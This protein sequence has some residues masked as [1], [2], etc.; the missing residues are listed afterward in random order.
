MRPETLI[1]SLLILMSYPASL[2]S[3]EGDPQVSNEPQVVAGVAVVGRP[4]VVTGDPGEPGQHPGGVRSVLPAP[5]VHGDQDR[6]PGRGGVNPGQRPGDPE[7]GLVEV[8]NPRGPDV[9]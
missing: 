1:R 4:G 5:G 8:G 3:K 2:L 7:P 9:R 6:L